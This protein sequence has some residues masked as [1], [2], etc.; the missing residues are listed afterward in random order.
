VAIR[1]KEV[2]SVCFDRE[3]DQETRRDQ[4][5]RLDEIRRLFARYRRIAR[6]ATAERDDAPEVPAEEP[7]ETRVLVGR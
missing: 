4:E 7:E 6:D 3:L 1:S 5:Q 2:V